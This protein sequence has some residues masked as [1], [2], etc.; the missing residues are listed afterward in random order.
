MKEN[1]FENEKILKIETIKGPNNREASICPKR[2]DI[3]TSLKFDGKEIIYLDE[4]TFKNTEVNVKGGIPILFPNAGPLDNNSEFP[5]LEQ[6]GFARK[7]EWSSEKVESGFSSS[8]SSND[9]TKKVYPFD[10]KFS[11]LGNFEVDGSFTLKQE[12]ENLEENKEMPISMGL[13]P[14]FK[15][16]SIEKNNIKFN[17]EGGKFIEEQVEIWANGKAISIDNPKIKNPNMPM[18]ITIPSLGTLIID[19]SVEYKKIWVWSMP[20]KDFVCVEPVMRDKNGLINDPEKIKPRKTFTTK[21]NFK[22]I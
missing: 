6:H 5:N 8:L 17:F 7:L 18:E 10:F 4:E 14:Y 21:V 22:L 15:V 2:G 16:P 9:D 19:P 11:V 12:V 20:G 13:H 3:L 1:N